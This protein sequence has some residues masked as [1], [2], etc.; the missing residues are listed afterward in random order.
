MGFKR[1][2]VQIAPLG[3]RGVMVKHDSSFSFPLDPAA[4]IRRSTA[5]NERIFAQFQKKIRKVFLAISYRSHRDRKTGASFLNT[6]GMTT[7]QE[8]YNQLRDQLPARISDGIRALPDLLYHA[9]NL[10]AVRLGDGV[11]VGAVD[12]DPPAVVLFPFSFR[13]SPS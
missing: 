3:P 4:V 8:A 12:R 11:E 9:Q 13:Q 5:Q 6:F 2:G 7:A 1:P 10:A